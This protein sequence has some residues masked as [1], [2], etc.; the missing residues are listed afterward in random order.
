MP[1]A[2]PLSSSLYMSPI[3]PGPTEKPG[4][5]PI[6]CTN[7]HDNSWGILREEATPKEPNTRSGTAV[8]YTGL[9]PSENNCLICEYINS[10]GEGSIT[11]SRIG[12]D[13]EG[14]QRRCEY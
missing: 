3:T 5:D 11:E 2:W 1:I 12:R 4:D 10:D 8:K 7:R 13:D 9:L 14:T 6:A